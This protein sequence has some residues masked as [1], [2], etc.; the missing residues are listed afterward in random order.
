M[1]ARKAKGLF[2][3]VNDFEV[4]AV[5]T[6]ALADPL[7]IE[8]LEVFPRS[9]ENKELQAFVGLLVDGKGGGK[10]YLKAH[11]GIYPPSRFFRRHTVESMAKAKEP[12][13]FAEVMRDQ[14]KVVPEKTM[15]AA[16]VTSTGESFDATKPLT[17]QKELLLAGAL[18]E[19]VA[20]EQELI[21]AS[22][23]YPEYLEL[24][25]LA[26]LGALQNYLKWKERKAP[27]LWLELGPASANLFVVSAGALE[28]CRPIPFGLD[29]M[30]PVV[31]QE[32]SLRD[33]DSARKLFFSNTFD[34][35]EMGPSLLRRIHKELH[36][37]M[38][39]FEMQTG[40]SLGDLFVSL[41]SPNLGWIP[42][43]LS[44]GLGLEML[45][46]DFPG[47]LA[48]R[49][50]AVGPH[51]QTAHLEARWLGPLSLMGNFEVN[52]GGEKE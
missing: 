13:Y 48:H 19:D 29:A 21:V 7:T 42:E 15:A 46:F 25:T 8:A 33:E 9:E 3:E 30:F 16:L 17:N 35:A 14:A 6:N 32:L 5:T 10:R 28:L 23:V 1:L 31:Q 20:T 27:V 50:I 49:E 38:G 43:T 39:F 51:V 52:N 11:C 18:S 34:F 45:E 36:A 12:G 47:W 40:Q 26:T 24:G 44:R 22:G 41:L 37:S 2:L 4:L